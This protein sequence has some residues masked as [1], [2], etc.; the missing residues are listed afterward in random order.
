MPAERTTTRTGRHKKLLLQV[1]PADTNNN[2]YTAPSHVLWAVVTKVVVCNATAGGLTFRLFHDIGGNIVAGPAAAD[3]DHALFWDKNVPANDS[4][5][6]SY[7][8]TD[9]SGLY[10]QPGGIIAF[11]SGSASNLTCSIYGYEELE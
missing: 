7:G 8:D 11:A 2:L 1:R 6:R 5:E 3:Q 4:I 9:D 10:V